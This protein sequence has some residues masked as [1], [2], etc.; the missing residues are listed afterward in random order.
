MLRKG[1]VILVIGFCILLG[2]FINKKYNSLTEKKTSE[3]AVVLL[4]GIKKVTKLVSVEGYFSE[5]YD[6]KDYYGVDFSLFRKKALIRIKAK[7]SVGY[8]FEKVNITIDK[9]FRTVTVGPIGPPQI[10]SIDHNLDYYDISE[11]T[12]NTFTADDYNQLNKNAKDYIVSQV[13]KSDL[14]NKADEQKDSILSMLKT[15]V[16]ANGWRFIVQKANI[17]K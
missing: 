2:I 14:L 17:V 7:V 9:N 6:Y 3:Q 10:L 13:N 11:G 12:F 5:I 1:L 4:E 16:E 8:D 15:L